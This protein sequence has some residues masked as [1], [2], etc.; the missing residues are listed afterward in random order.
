ML[1]L[2]ADEFG[3]K[4]EAVGRTAEQVPFVTTCALTNAMKA[5]RFNDDPEDLAG[6]PPTRF[7]R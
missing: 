2:N 5:V 3:T 1:V 7:Y 6:R 4:I